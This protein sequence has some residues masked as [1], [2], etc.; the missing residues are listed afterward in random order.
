MCTRLTWFS[1]AAGGSRFGE[2]LLGANR[3]TGAGGTKP[4]AS[5]DGLVRG[6]GSWPQFPHLQNVGIY[7]QFSQSR[8]LDVPG[9]AGYLGE[10]C[11]LV[12]FSKSL[13]VEPRLASTSPSSCL[14]VP[15]AGIHEL[16]GAS[17]APIRLQNKKV[18]CR[19]GMRLKW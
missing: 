19:L 15:S 14:S 4:G 10:F 17:W 11:L 8:K 18:K 3:E 6:S 2:L 9:G 12:F 16:A 1:A 13:S 5:T 7:G